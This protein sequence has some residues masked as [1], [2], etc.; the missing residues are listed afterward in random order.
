MKENDKNQSQQFRLP[1]AWCSSLCRNAMNQICVESCAIKRDCSSFD[2]KPNLELIDMPSFPLNKSAEMTKE[3]K[4]TV[5]TVYLAKVV[6]QLAGR[7]EKSNADILYQAPSEPVKPT[8]KTVSE[9]TSL[10]L[11]RNTDETKE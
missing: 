1:P 4:F 11:N 5:V 2:P 7:E 8:Q 3:E 10:L 6:D 9:I